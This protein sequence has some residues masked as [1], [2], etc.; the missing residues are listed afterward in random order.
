LHGVLPRDAR[1]RAARIAV[2][3]HLAARFEKVAM[4]QHPTRED[5]T[6]L[7]EAVRGEAP[8]PERKKPPGP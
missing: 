3:K 1:R 4:K 2:G 6:A 5:W 7:P 8:T